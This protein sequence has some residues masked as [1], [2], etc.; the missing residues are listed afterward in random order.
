ME[1]G[2]IEEK[3]R[4]TEMEEEVSKGEEE[5]RDNKDREEGRKKMELVEDN[6]D[7]SPPNIV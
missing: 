3:G 6:Q 5:L 4:R 2:T 1:E 7:I